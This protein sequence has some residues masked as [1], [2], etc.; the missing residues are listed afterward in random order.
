MKLA[1]C[2]LIQLGLF[3][4]LW[5]A[6]NDFPQEP[7]LG[8]TI[9]PVGSWPTAMAV[10]DTATVEV[11]VTDDAGR[12]LTG[13]VVEWLSSDAGTITVSRQT[14]PDSLAIGG[15]PCFAGVP[16]RPSNQRDSLGTQLKATLTAR[17]SGRGR[18]T[19]TVAHEGLKPASVSLSVDIQKWAL[20][21]ANVWPDTIEGVAESD[22]LELMV[23]NA[24]SA[25]A[26][27]IDV[28]W[29]SSAPGLSVSAVEPPLFANRAQTLDAKLRAIISAC[30]LG[31][32]FVTVRVT[33]E[34]FESAELQHQVV[35]AGGNGNR[36]PLTPAALG[37]SRPTPN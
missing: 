30:L 35:V 1:S 7:P 27:D 12:A 6:C 2:G 31:T 22:T 8:V 16:C 37:N 20:A 24:D 18:V 17:R 15:G 11:M 25:L 13:A 21:K 3:S 28:V 23:P 33:R 36:C 19:A 29:R 9:H 14:P 4:A 34:S 10:T 5:A 26:Y 32:Y